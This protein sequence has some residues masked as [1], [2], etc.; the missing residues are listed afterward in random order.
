MTNSINQLVDCIGQRYG[1]YDPF[2]IAEKLNIAIKWADIY[3]RPFGNTIYYEKSPIIL[4]SNVIKETPEKYFVCSHELGHAI[5]HEGLTAY[6]IAN[7]K[8]HNRSESEADKF[9][10]SLCTHLYIEQFDKMPETYSDI[11]AQY[12]LPNIGIE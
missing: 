6:Y 9:A 1:T 8:F 4:L 2:V 3:P 11:Q 5:V 7:S 12:G 10:I